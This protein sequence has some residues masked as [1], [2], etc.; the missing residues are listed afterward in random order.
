MVSSRRWLLVAWDAI[1]SARVLRTANTDAPCRRHKTR[2]HHPV[3]LSWY[4]ANQSW[5]YHA[6]AH[7]G[8]PHKTLTHTH[9]HTHKGMGGGSVKTF[10]NSKDQKWS[11][12]LQLKNFPRLTRPLHDAVSLQSAA[13]QNYVLTAWPMVSSQSKS[14]QC[15]IRGMWEC[16]ILP[17]YPGCKITDVRWS[18]RGKWN[19]TERMGQGPFNCRQMMRICRKLDRKA[20]VLIRVTP[21]IHVVSKV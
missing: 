1:S 13:N 9:T 8:A 6:H 7:A 4:R 20:R 14:R 16:V 18:C 21:N 10:Q 15:V 19:S 11:V 17:H 2:M 5:F 12:P 3:T